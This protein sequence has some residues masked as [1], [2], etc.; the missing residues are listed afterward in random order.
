MAKVVSYHLNV[1]RVL[2]EKLGIELDTIKTKD[3]VQNAVENLKS[4]L[5]A[6]E[7]KTNDLLNLLTSYE[8]FKQDNDPI[9]DLVK[10]VKSLIKPE[11]V[12]DITYL[13]QFH[14][15]EQLE[16]QLGVQETRA[17]NFV[18]VTKDSL[19]DYL[20]EKQVEG[21]H[22][23]VV[24]K[25]NHLSTAAFIRAVEN[26]SYSSPVLTNDEIKELLDK[27]V[28]IENVTKVKLK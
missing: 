17:V 8:A 13:K 3:G 9:D 18:G 20:L 12:K 5:N 11:D 19:F 10:G 16:F 14:Q 27:C 28:V 4:R 21:L 24:T 26:Q 1:F 15:G 7:V 23:S 25:V 2:K 22:S 6:G